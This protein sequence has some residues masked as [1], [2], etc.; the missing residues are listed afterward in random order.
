MPDIFVNEV[1]EKKEE[2]FKK[3]ETK[4]EVEELPGH[5][6]SP[7]TAFCFYP[8]GID[9][10]TRRKEEKIVLLMR[11]HIVT[12]VGWIIIGVI[13]ILAPLVLSKFPILE[14]LPARFQFVAILGWYLITMAFIL[15]GFL[16]WF[17]NVYIVTNQ[18]VVDI[19]FYNL[20]YKEVSDAKIDKVQDV[21]Y[22]MGGVIRTIFDY[23]DVFIQTAAE[24]P[25]FEFL[26]VPRPNVVAK[27]LE[28]LIANGEKGLRVK[29]K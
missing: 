4:K 14:F 7:L 10:E 8:D 12:N 13:M 23:G 28:D 20:I 15:E 25:N 29:I 6:H 9:F 2:I 26:A 11:K 19:D 22:R 18:R 17:F 16:D 5:S 24:V 27:I 21:T 1:P 3:P